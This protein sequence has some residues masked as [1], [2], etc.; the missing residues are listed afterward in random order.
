MKIE[1]VS[2]SLIKEY[3]SFLKEDTCGSVFKSKFIDRDWKQ[4][5]WDSPAMKLGRYFEF[6][7]TGALPAYG[8][9]VPEPEYL[10][11]SL[12]K[13]AA[14][15]DYV[16]EVKDM[17]DPYREVHRKAKLTGGLIAKSG[18]VFQD[19]QIYR[20]KGV[21]NGHIDLEALYNGEEINIDIKYSGLIDDKWSKFGWVWTRDQMDYNGIQAKQY[22]AINRRPTY[23][24]VISSAKSDKIK[25]FKA[26]V[27][28]YDLDQHIKYAE[29]LPKN[30]EFINKVG[31]TNYPTLDKCSKCPLSLKCDDKIVTLIPEEIIIKDF[32]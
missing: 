23:F 28:S 11:S 20:E 22:E 14:N 9:E 21:L 19:I 24:L 17:K 25:F 30:I 12:K 18:I 31:W 2:Q 1:K 13:K 7:L 4:E 6:I 10:V 29:S 32:D 16:F 5:W 8:E 27:D 15:D 26:T 3:N